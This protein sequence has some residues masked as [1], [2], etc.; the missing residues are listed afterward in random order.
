MQINIDPEDDDSLTKNESLIN[1]SPLNGEKDAD[2]PKESLLDDSPLRED[3]EEDDSGSRT[4]LPP[5]D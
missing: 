5:P 2:L 3:K 4:V 1:D